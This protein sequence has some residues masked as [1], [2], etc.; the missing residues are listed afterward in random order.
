MGAVRAEHRRGE[1]REPDRAD[2][3]H[4][5]DRP[6]RELRCR[7]D[8]GDQERDREEVEQPVREHC[9]EQRRARSGPARKMPPQHRDSRKLAGPRREHG[10]SEETHAERREHLREGRQR[11]RQGLVDGEVPGESA[12][13]HG[14]Q[15]QDTATTTQRQLTKPN[16]S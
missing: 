14:E 13:E 15:V 3:H 8:V 6:V 4:A 11:R 10:V 16:E 1:E 5:G 9:S 2:D 7:G 12:G